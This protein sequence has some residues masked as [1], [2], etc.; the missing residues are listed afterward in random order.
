[1]KMETICIYM[2]VESGNNHNDN[3]LLFLKFEFEAIMFVS[4]D[5]IDIKTQFNQNFTTSTFL[6]G[7]Q[8]NLEITQFDII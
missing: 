2:K 1:M 8:M 6:F 4:F 7:I 3:F 5:I